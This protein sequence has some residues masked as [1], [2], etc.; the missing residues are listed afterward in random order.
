MFIRAE[1][2]SLENYARQLLHQLKFASNYPDYSEFTKIDD[3]LQAV[4]KQADLNEM[5]SQYP[6]ITDIFFHIIIAGSN[7]R[8][9]WQ[10][11]II[12]NIVSL[13]D[14]KSH[15]ELVTKLKQMFGDTPFFKNDVLES[16]ASLEF[17]LRQRFKENQEKIKSI[18]QEAE[19]NFNENLKYLKQVTASNMD[20]NDIVEHLI[21]AKYQLKFIPAEKRRTYLKEYIDALKPIH[22]LCS[23][24]SEKRNAE[25]IRFFIEKY[26]NIPLNFCND[27]VFRIIGKS[28]L[29]NP[30]VAD[31]VFYNDLLEDLLEINSDFECSIR[32]I[33]DLCRSLVIPVQNTEVTRLMEIW[34]IIDQ[35]DEYRI[36]AAAAPEPELPEYLIR[37][38]RAQELLYKLCVKQAYSLNYKGVGKI[39]SMSLH[40]KIDAYG[41]V[42]E[43]VNPLLDYIGMNIFC[44]LRSSRKSSQGMID[45]FYQ[46]RKYLDGEHSDKYLTSM[47]I[48]ICSWIKDSFLWTKKETSPPQMESSDAPIGN[49]DGE[50]DIKTLLDFIE[51]PNNEPDSDYSEKILKIIKE[52]HFDL[53]L[54]LMLYKFGV[55]PEVKKLLDNFRDGGEIPVAIGQVLNKGEIRKLLGISNTHF[56]KQE[57]NKLKGTL[58]HDANPE[59]YDLICEIKRYLNTKKQ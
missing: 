43:N 30:V 4:E 56:F 38:M 13:L 34:N 47:I 2:I 44:Y 5:H 28:D 11:W 41:N 42:I 55:T 16:C 59:F 52:N 49:S 15:P 33:F 8:R 27:A 17:L 48:N 24:Y 6:F 18:R 21:L 25:K 54:Y 46:I 35:A 58:L 36:R 14:L 26:E 20:G 37:G 22:E 51:A 12:Q 39:P 29:C 53:Y 19:D 23:L 50:D 10:I 1:Q 40:G 45:D 3:L 57:L 31:K 9:I 32:D 7:A